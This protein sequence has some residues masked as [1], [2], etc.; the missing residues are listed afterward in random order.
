MEDNEYNVIF[1]SGKSQFVE[2]IGQFKTTLPKSTDS[3]AVAGSVANKAKI[4]D[5]SL[6]NE[7]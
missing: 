5:I 1:M 2:C 4:A 3:F 6:S 7:L